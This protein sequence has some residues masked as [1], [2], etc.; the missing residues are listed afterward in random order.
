MSRWASFCSASLW[1]DLKFNH[2]CFGKYGGMLS[3]NPFTSPPAATTALQN[4]LLP[5]AES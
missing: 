2:D 5:G 4:S 1:R 3:V